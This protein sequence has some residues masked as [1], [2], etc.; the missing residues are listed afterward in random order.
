L[1][2]RLLTVFALALFALPITAF[3][4]A[5]LRQDGCIPFEEG[6]IEYVDVWFTAINFSLPAELCDIHLIPEPQP[7]D[8]ACIIIQCSAPPGWSCFLRADGGADW[9]AN[10]PADCISPGSALSGF[11][12]VLDPGYCCY[13]VQFTGPAGD[14]LLEQEECFCDKTVGTEESTWGQIKSRY[15]G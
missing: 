4:D 2:K 1:K 9:F 3:A 7:P 13:I 5:S 12:F 11:H 14:V 8:P 6:G 10:T 15:E